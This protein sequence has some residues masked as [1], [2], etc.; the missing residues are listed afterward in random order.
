MPSTPRISWDDLNERQRTYLLTIYRHDQAEE[1]AQRSGWSRGIRARPADEW[2]WMYYGEYDYGSSPLKRALLGTGMVDQGTGSTFESLRSRGLVLVRS[3]HEPYR[4]GEDAVHVRM[5]TT[6]RKLA[7]EATAEVHEKKL[8]AGTLRAWHWRALAQLYRAGAIT[9]DGWSGDYYA[10]DD[11]QHDWR[12]RTTWETLR[13][14]LEYKWGALCHEVHFISGGRYELTPYGR[15]Y[16][17]REWARY[18]EL[19]PD[20]D[21]PEPSGSTS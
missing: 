1:E 7:R 10:V 21:A 11:E 18:R 13:R 19:Y 20:V 3:F 14:L 6:G 9:G 12:N 5:T 15:A 8:P 17:E 16:Y 2:R 4:G